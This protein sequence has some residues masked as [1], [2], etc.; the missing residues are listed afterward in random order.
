MAVRRGARAP[1]GLHESARRIAG[2]LPFLTIWTFL[3]LALVAG[4]SH[5]ED[6]ARSQ[7]LIAL[8]DALVTGFSGIREMDDG[9]GTA[10]HSRLFLDPDGASLRG[11]D[12]SNPTAS[13]P[14]GQRLAPEFLSV[15]ARDIGQ[16]FGV[17]LDDATDQETKLHAPN[18]YVT[19]TSA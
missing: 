12:L 19:A 6:V 1:T 8:G 10:N 16:V 17:A 4:S 2:A 18:I 14:L 5:A 15:P 7:P 3:M 13:G 11:F 9:E